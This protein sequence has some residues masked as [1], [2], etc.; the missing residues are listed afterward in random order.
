MVKKGATGM[1]VWVWLEIVLKV[2]WMP[3]F[4]TTQRVCIG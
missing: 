2:R 1:K 3:L 4:I